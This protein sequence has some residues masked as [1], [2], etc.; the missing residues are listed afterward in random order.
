LLRT[1]ERRVL[2]AYTSKGFRLV[3]RI[4]RDAW[5]ALVVQKP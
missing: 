4:H 5:A 2:A 3:R 1:Q